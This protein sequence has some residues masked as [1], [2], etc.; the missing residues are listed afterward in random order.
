MARENHWRYCEACKSLFHSA[1]SGVP[2]QVCPT[3]RMTAWPYFSFPEEHKAR[4]FNFTLAFDDPP[5][6]ILD[7]FFE[8]GWR[9]CPKCTCLV[10]TGD[11]S[12]GVCTDGGSHDSRPADFRLLYVGQGTPGDQQA[13][14]RRCGR[15]ECLF[16]GRDAPDSRCAA[17]GQHQ[18]AGTREYVLDYPMHIS[19]T[20]H[21]EGLGF[22]ATGRGVTPDSPV[23]CQ[24][25]WHLRQGPDGRRDREGLEVRSDRDGAFYAHFTKP[26]V[27]LAWKAAQVWVEDQ[28]TH[29]TSAA[30]INSW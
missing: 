13:G 22:S 24:A 19:L 8:V 3:R 17:G 28:W 30:N 11:G 21:K 9:E 1:R 20:L 12:G 23:H 4:G 14:W 7:Q 25:T 2:K 6:L 26:G 15:C 18:I 5:G 29:V 10:Y 27:D 16:F